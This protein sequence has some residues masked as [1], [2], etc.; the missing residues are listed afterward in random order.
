MYRS[1]IAVG[2]GVWPTGRSSRSSG[3][4]T[5]G[6]SMAKLD[7]RQESDRHAEVLDAI[8]KFLGLGSYLQWDEVSRR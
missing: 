6:I 7:L 3:V 4:R 1:L 2:D 5:F 8:T